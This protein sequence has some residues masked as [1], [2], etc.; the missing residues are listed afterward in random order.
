MKSAVAATTHCLLS[1][2]SHTE[3]LIAA[4]PL[5]MELCIVGVLVRARMVMT[6]H[7]VAAVCDHVI[8]YLIF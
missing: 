2:D 1:E 6:V 5:A 3:V 4:V 8:A 7:A